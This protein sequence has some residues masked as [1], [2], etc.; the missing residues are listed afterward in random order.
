MQPLFIIGAKFPDA[1]KTFHNSHASDE[2]ELVGI[3]DDDPNLK[4]T[5]VLGAKVLG[6]IELLKNFQNPGVFNSIAL[7]KHSRLAAIKKL[8]SYKIE[9]VSIV[10]KSI[11]LF[12]VTIGTGCFASQTSYFE[13]SS[14]IGSGSMVLAG[15]TIGH[16]SVIGENC[17]I[18]PGAH[19]CGKVEIGPFSWIGA[20][21]TIHPCSRLGEG[22]V[23]DMNAKVVSRS[24]KSL[25]FLEVRTPGSIFNSK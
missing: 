6:G 10:H 13:G 7:S 17:F 18:S 14:V 20:G 16:D 23:V 19:I 25:R 4:N 1:I 2:Y 22:S 9:L 21:A 11:D 5:E 3:L 15:A 8:Q 24:R 12:G